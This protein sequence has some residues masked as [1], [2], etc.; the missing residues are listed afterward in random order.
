MFRLR[1]APVKVVGNIRHGRTGLVPL[2]KHLVGRTLA[3]QLSLPSGH[4]TGVTSVAVV[5]ALLVLRAT[6]RPTLAACVT[7]LVVATL[8]GLAIGAVMV[9]L[10][11]HYPTDIMAGWAVAVACTLGTALA[12]DRLSG[13]RGVGELATG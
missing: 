7:G 3:G 2:G 6:D 9:L 8:A 5:V 13:E 10:R 4:T 1:Q 12:I 11:F